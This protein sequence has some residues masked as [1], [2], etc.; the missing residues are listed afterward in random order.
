MNRLPSTHRHLGGVMLRARSVLAVA[1]AVAVA[2]CSSGEDGQPPGEAVDTDE[3]GEA[4]EPPDDEDAAEPTDGGSE[5]QPTEEPVPE[6]PAVTEAPPRPDLG[7]P[8]IELTTPAAGGGS[9]PDLAWDPV[10]GAAAY[11]VTLYDP[12][13]SAYWAW[14]GDG[15]TVVVGGF[16]AAPSEGSGVAPRIQPGMSWDVTAHGDDGGLLAQSGERPI[17]P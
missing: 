3:V 7:L 13:G 12:Q 4:S 9:W 16:A 2:A 10:D 8:G 1:L 5:P 17:G 11:T 15:T 14:T 6:E